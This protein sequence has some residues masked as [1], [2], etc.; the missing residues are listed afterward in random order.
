MRLNH[1]FLGAAFVGLASHAVAADNPRG[2]EPSQAFGK[3][4]LAFEANVG[5]T[6][7]QV[8]YF[9]RGNGYTAFL[10]ANEAVL[11]LTKRVH[12]SSVSELDEAFGSERG[13]YDTLSAAVRMRFQGAKAQPVTTPSG[14][15]PARISYLSASGSAPVQPTLFQKVSYSDVWPGVSVDFYGNQ[16]Q[17]EYDF[18]VA[19]GTAPSVIKLAFDGA[20]AIQVEPSSGDL[21]LTTEI[22][23]LRQ[24]APV[25]YQEVD[26]QRVTVE[27]QYALA[28]NQ[29]GFQIGSFDSTKPLVIDPKLTFAVEW[30]G[31]G[32]DYGTSVA[33]NQ[34]NGEIY[35]AGYTNSP[36][37]PVTNGSQ[38][39]GGLDVFVSK[40]SADGKTI[41][42]STYIGGSYDDVA[43][44]IALDG[45]GN[46]YITGYTESAD[47]PLVC[48]SCA[49]QPLVVVAPA[50]TPAKLF[51][52][53]LA[54]TG[55]IVFSG[56]Y[57]GNQN[58]YGNAIAVDPTGDLVAVA[59]RTYSPDFPIVGGTAHLRGSSDAFLAIIQMQPKVPFQIEPASPGSI[60][61]STYIGGSGD[62]SG[63]SVALI[64][65]K[66][67]VADV[68][69]AG[70][71][72]SFDFPVT[73]GA[74][75]ATYQGG[76]SDAFVTRLK[77][78]LAYD[79]FG[80]T[81][82]P[83]PFAQ[84]IYSTYLGG[85]GQDVVDSVTTD[86]NG[87]SYL[88]G[89]TRSRYYFPTTF[90][91]FQR[92]Y[93]GGN[94][95]AFIVKLDPNGKLLYATYF[96]GSG[97]DYGETILVGYGALYLVGYTDSYDL[98]LTGDAFQP[99]EAGGW[100]TFTTIFL[101]DYVTLFY[102]S[103]FGTWGDDY[104]YGAALDS[105]GNLIFAGSTNAT[106][107]GATNVLLLK[108][109][110]GHANTF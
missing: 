43:R 29:V 5:Q 42:F 59:G 1:V 47:Y 100:D 9:A 14:P 28:G 8:K 82:R 31:S 46:A 48:S 25:V 51:V 32:Q 62:E 20:Q 64:P 23:E 4:P 33:V 55:S 96:G 12:R 101:D 83:Y 80:A 34:N 76:D 94:S 110:V 57:G 19:P 70:W 106:N 68:V 60:L 41:L 24:P 93:G 40:I 27:G 88:T 107:T 66:S 15:M 69:V 63:R 53:E 71:T 38:I 95:D 77:V 109:D 78:S 90:G 10:T 99:G 45:Y 30:G 65:D 97:D 16:R 85:E 22:G 2:P 79:V 105:V 73:S 98:P 74:Q 11:A 44:G 36:N 7:P 37:F 6:D 86:A 50:Q 92:S 39:R 108:L 21:V 58:D 35:V 72:S 84:T 104:A 17:L 75:Q 61:F 52:V 56:T 91:C 81:A 54:P 103:Y 67:V 18:V 49:A 3:V 89:Y 87:F 13:S 102:S 26:G